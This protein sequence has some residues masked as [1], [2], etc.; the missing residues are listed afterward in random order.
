MLKPR[1]DATHIAKMNKRYVRKPRGETRLSG[2]CP[3]PEGL[4][5]S[6]VVVRTQRG[7][8]ESLVADRT[9]RGGSSSPLR[10]YVQVYFRYESSSK[11]PTKATRGGSGCA[12]SRVGVS[13]MWLRLSSHPGWLRG[14]AATW[15]PFSQTGFNSAICSSKTCNDRGLNICTVRNF[16]YQRLLR[17]S[18][19]HETWSSQLDSLWSNAVTLALGK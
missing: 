1:G 14:V 2:S 12:A 3:H 13:A 6:L 4:A 5:Q 18:P 17:S 15:I 8:P 19:I 7:E 11:P 16:P 10:T 9:Q